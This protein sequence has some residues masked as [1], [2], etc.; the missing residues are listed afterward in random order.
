MFLFWQAL[1][2]SNWSRE[3]EGE[4]VLTVARR[5]NFTRPSFVLNLNLTKQYSTID[6]P[7]DPSLR[8]EPLRLIEHFVDRLT[9]PANLIVAL[10]LRE[11][12]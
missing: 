9:E 11:R 6:R 10:L 12:L 2:D 8:Q 4:R 1:S 7:I 5:W 3:T